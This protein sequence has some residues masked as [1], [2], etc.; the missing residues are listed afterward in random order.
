MKLTLG[1]G[2]GRENPGEAEIREAI[3]S[4]SGGH[5][6]FVI[7]SRDDQHYIQAA[8]GGSEGFI[9]EYREGAW[10]RH[11]RCQDTALPGE[12]VTEAFISYARGGG[13][14]ESLEWVVAEGPPQST[15]TVILILLG[16]VL[17]VGLV[18]YLV[19]RVV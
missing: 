10:D 1:P 5:D 17:I 3:R 11:F 7:L 19:A 6:S 4:L 12:A 14:P 15:R 13:R 8:G 2:G 16:F 9:L 18:A